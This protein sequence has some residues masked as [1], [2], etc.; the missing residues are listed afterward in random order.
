MRCNNTLLSPLFDYDHE[1][2]MQKMKLFTLL[3]STLSSPQGHPVL[4]CDDDVVRRGFF[5][6]PI[7]CFT[8]I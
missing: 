6:G 5:C 3:P 1:P 2:Y 4:G 7:D 8:D